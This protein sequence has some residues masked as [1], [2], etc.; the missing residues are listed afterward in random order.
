MVPGSIAHTLITTNGLVT[1]SWLAVHPECLSNPPDKLNYSPIDRI[2]KLGVTS[3]ST[4]NTWR[5]NRNEANSKRLDYVFINQRRAEV[6]D[7]LVVFTELV[8]K[9]RCSYSDHF[10]ISVKLRLINEKQGEAETHSTGILSCSLFDTIDKISNVYLARQV[11]QSR[12]RIAS[13][14]VAVVVFLGAL[15]GQWWIEPE[16]GHFILLLGTVLIMVYGTVDGLIG[17]VFGRWELRALKE[18][19]SEMQL[20]RTAYTKEWNAS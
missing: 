16:Y 4:W 1:D 12:W 20:A 13:F 17:F 6:V 9:L 19:V 5:A 8:P 15:V 2:R 10:G 3:N 18:F 7:S 11:R 14:F